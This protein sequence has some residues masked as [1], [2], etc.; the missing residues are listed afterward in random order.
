MVLA[1]PRCIVVCENGKF[2]AKCLS[3]WFLQ[4]MQT[5]FQFCYTIDYSIK[6]VIE[7]F[8]ANVLDEIIK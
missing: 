6:H 7:L 5:L 3:A 1:K 4:F 8:G 2:N